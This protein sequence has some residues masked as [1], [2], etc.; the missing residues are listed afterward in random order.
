MTTLVERPEAV[1]ADPVVGAAAPGRPRVA[2]RDRA[3][4]R[5][6]AVLL[7]LL[8]T[9][10]VVVPVFVFSTVITFALGAASGL[11]PAAALAGDNA[12]PEMIAS[13]EAQYGLDQPLAVQY[14]HWIGGILTG[15]FGTSWFNNTPVAE[16]IGQRLAIS[17]SI[18]GFA[19]LIGLVFGTLLGL[20]AAVNQG[21]FVDRAITAFSSF[22]STLPPFVVSIGLIVVFC[23]LVPVFPS[24][25]YVSPAEDPSAWLTLITLPAI[26]LSLDAVSDIA[27]QLRTGLVAAQR[28]NYVTGAIV[29]GLSPRRILWGHVLRNGAGPALSV[30]GLRVPMLIGGAVVTES[31]FGM[32]GFG[33]FAADGAVRGDVPVVQ[34]TLVV[35]IVVVLVFN[36]LVNAV[37]VR[38]RPAAG[39]GF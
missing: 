28:E 17:A 38:L 36:L 25:G 15:D 11:N 18:A 5:V 7:W 33:R 31:I 10:L 37:L 6:R 12:T 34:G 39:R 35:A 32:A 24:A 27:R 4:H 13:I 29:R 9:V 3:A 20:V 1:T 21:R 22:I 26:A 16:L 8:R 2:S 23:V 19:L 14:L 30:L